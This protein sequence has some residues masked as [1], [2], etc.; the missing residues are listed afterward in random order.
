V[1]EEAAKLAALWVIA[2]RLPRYTTR[3]SSPIV[4]SAGLTPVRHVSRR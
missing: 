2:W 4:F 1:I 3:P